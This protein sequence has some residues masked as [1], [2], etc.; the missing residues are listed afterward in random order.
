MLKIEIEDYESIQNNWKYSWSRCFEEEIK[1]YTNHLHI[2]QSGI[3]T[4]DVRNYTF[5][6]N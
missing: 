1:V 5:S 6:E 3:S 4:N 2:I